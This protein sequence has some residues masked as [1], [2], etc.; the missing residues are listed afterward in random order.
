MFKFALMAT[1]TAAS[2]VAASAETTISTAQLSPE[3]AARVAQLQTYG[4]RYQAAIDAILAEA[5]MDGY[6]WE[7]STAAVPPVDVVRLPV[8]VAA[9]VEELRTYGHRFDKAIDAIL[10]E[11]SME[12]F[13][14]GD[15]ESVEHVIVALAPAS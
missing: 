5:A 4:D 15:C 9:R 7:A 12:E 11:A 8:E 6:R 2:T 1:L 14:W 10:L 13:R 3:V